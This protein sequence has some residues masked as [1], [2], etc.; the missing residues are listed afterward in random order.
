MENFFKAGG[1]G[2]EEDEGY[3]T[4]RKVDERGEHLV[5][6]KMARFDGLLHVVDAS[7]LKEALVVGIG[8]TKAFGCGLLSLARGR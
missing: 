7:L 3:A 2:R 5:S 6:I 8:P 4:G 1:G